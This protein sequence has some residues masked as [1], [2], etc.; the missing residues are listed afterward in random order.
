MARFMGYGPLTYYK[1]DKA[2]LPDAWLL[3]FALEFG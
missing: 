3:G 1:S 2:P